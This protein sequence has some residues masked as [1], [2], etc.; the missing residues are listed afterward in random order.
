MIMYIVFFADFY[1]FFGFFLSTNVNKKIKN[2]NF[3]KNL[4]NYGKAVF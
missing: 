1:G 3:E 4:K 2:E